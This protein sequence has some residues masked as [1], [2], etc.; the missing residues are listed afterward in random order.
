MTYRRAYFELPILAYG[1]I[2]GFSLLSVC[3]KKSWCPNRDND[4][5]HSLN[6]R[7][8]VKVFSPPFDELLLL[9]VVQQQWWWWWV[10]SQ[11][12]LEGWCRTN[13]LP[14]VGTNEGC[15]VLTIL[16]GSIHQRGILT[17]SGGSIQGILTVLLINIDATV[18][19]ICEISWT[20]LLVTE[21]LLHV[22]M[23]RPSKPRKTRQQ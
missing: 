9:F 21:W 23:P 7:V 10:A 19:I 2:Q 4:T 1:Q 8:S 22:N 6:V 16:S 17:I 5:I 11:V 18:H 14:F 12:M 15:S 20:V 3:M 13:G